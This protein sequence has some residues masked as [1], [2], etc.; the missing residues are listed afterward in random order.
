MVVFDANAILMVLKPDAPHPVDR[1]KDR[2]E[3][4][5]TTLE[6]GREKIIIPAPCLAEVLV[7][8]GSASED[9][10]RTLNSTTRFKIEP[11]DQIAA[12]ELANMHRAA[13]KKGDKRGDTPNAAWPKVVF[14]RQIVAI[15]K[16]SSARAIYS[17]DADVYKHGKT[18]GIEVIRVADLPLPKEEQA[19]LFDVKENA[20]VTVGGE[21]EETLPKTDEILPLD[22]S[23]KPKRNN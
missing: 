12:I 1:A 6:E 5:I 22:T 11:F 9:Y 4:L 20:P 8:S 19:Q 10:L 23:D 21:E 15:A 16:A 18:A 13:I 2:I 17:D 14:D 7:W 3:F